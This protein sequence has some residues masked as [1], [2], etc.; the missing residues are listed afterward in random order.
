MQQISVRVSK[1]TKVNNKS[2]MQKNILQQNK[3]QINCQKQR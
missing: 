3:E 2:Q 1:N